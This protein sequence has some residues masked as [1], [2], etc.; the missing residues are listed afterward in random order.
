MLL[1]GLMHNN[2]RAPKGSMGVVVTLKSKMAAG[3]WGDRK[4]RDLE[5]DPK[6]NKTNRRAVTRRPSHIRTR[7]SITAIWISRFGEIRRQCVWRHCAQGFSLGGPCLVRQRSLLLTSQSSVFFA[8]TVTVF[9][10]HAVFSLNTL[11]CVN[12]PG[13]G[14]VYGSIFPEYVPLTSQNLYPFIVYFWSIWGDFIA[15]S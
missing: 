15:P 11:L 3:I 9:L 12:L 7:V 2:V 6:S 13:G 1:A 4:V 5:L 14:G 8:V 10:L